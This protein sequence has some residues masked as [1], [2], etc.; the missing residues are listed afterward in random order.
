[1]DAQNLLLLSI[2]LA[3]AGGLAALALNK[4]GELANQITGWSAFAAGLAGLT[5]GIMVL[6]TGQGFKLELAGGFPFT[7]F[8]LQVDRLSAFM[9]V[10]ISFLVL[11][12]SLYSIKY[13]DEYLEKNPGVLGFLINLFIASML[14]VVTVGNAL[15]FLIFWEVM[16]MVSY[17]L[18]IY[19][20]D[21]L[22]M[23]AGFLYF[24]VAHGGTALIMLAFLLLYKQA[25]S[26]DFD[27]F[28]TAS[29]DPKISS[30]IFVLAFIGFAA[31]AGAVPLHFW[32]PEA[33]SAAPSN[34]SSLLS[35]V[36]IKTA[37]YMII[38]VCIEF[39]GAET[40]WWGFVVLVVGVVSTV[41]G[42]L[43]ALTQHDIKRLLAFHSV[44]YIGIILMGVGA[45]MLGIALDKPVIVVVG[46]MAALYHLFNHA[47]FKGLLFLGAGSVIYRTHTRNMEELGGMAKLMPWTA[48]FFFMGG[49]AISA[50]PPLNGFVSK[51]FIY[52]SL[53]SIGLNGDAVDKT[54]VPLFA[55][56][57]ALAGA[58][59]A[60][61]IVKAYGVTFT[62]LFRGHHP[63]KEAKEVPA[64]MLAGKGILAAG[65]IL[66][67]LGAPLLAPQIA[68][69]VATVL[70]KPPAA[71]SS[72]LLV[73]PGAAT[74]A[75]LSTP[76]VA[77]LFA[78]LLLVPVVV[79]MATG[80]GKAGS[81]IDATPWAAGYKYTS[82]MAVQPRSFGQPVQSLFRSVLYAHTTYQEHGATPGKY[83]KQVNYQVEMEDVWDKFFLKPLAQSIAWFSHRVQILQGGNLRVYCLYIII[84]LAVLLI[85][86]EV[87]NV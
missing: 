35:G 12:V 87:L 81:R 83:F 61:C 4:S 54:F 39:L 16:T 47:I 57:L 7:T 45:G 82:Q 70:E 37:I 5:S 29:L 43:Y 64:E 17:F 59:T 80:G 14:L 9:I 10:V 55:M 71:V 31:K 13:L 56:L 63:L 27:A 23:R 21:K 24:L 72:G 50:I 22:S 58:G 68:T 20:Q 25:G 33:H 79:V 3:V 44:E 86:L 28:R 1:M 85:A 42:P 84:T 76:L 36:M 15:Y 74:Q 77:L 78:V 73:F 34:V 26:L 46:L 52:Q 51:W 30:I 69:A 2:F 11:A 60:M 6:V 19:E 53:F 40:W 32:L 18:V 41:L 67:G 48:L 49:V 38:R 75:T 62:G 66:A 65:T 8:V